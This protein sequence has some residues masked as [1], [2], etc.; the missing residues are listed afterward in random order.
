MGHSIGVIIVYDV[1]NKETF[2]NCCKTWLN[3][4]RDFADADAAILLLGH[5]SDEYFANPSKREVSE[6]EARE[7]A[8]NNEVLYMEASGSLYYN[9]QEAFEILIEGTNEISLEC[10]SFNWFHLEIRNNRFNEPSTGRN[11][12]ARTSRTESCIQDPSPRTQTQ[13][14]TSN[15]THSK[16]FKK[17]SKA[18]VDSSSCKIF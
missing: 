4:A 18:D 6:I 7:F 3:F 2:Q 13:V 5:L 1:T 9:I 14:V 15:R 12:E 8:E 17:K 11:S 10:Q 16:K